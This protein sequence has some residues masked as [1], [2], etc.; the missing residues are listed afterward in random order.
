MTTKD[1]T[2]PKLV[3]VTPSKGS[4]AI[5]LNQNLILTFSEDIQL[6][7]IGNITLNDGYN[8]YVVPVNSSQITVRANKL[9]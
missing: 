8:A 4:E 2:A 5:E 3:S 9:V 1:K 7:N 6:G